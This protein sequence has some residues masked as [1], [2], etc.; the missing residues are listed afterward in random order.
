MSNTE[1]KPFE[2]AIVRRKVRQMIGREGFTSQ[3]YQP[4]EQELIARLLHGLQSFDPTRARHT[5]FV[6]AIVQRSAAH[7]LRYHRAQKR[8]H[9]RLIELQRLGSRRL[10]RWPSEATELV[11]DVEEVIAGPPQQLRWLAVQL[12][13]KSL[14]QIARDSGIPRSTL[15]HR[16][17]ELRERF[18]AANVRI[19][20]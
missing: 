7:I 2:H 12:K 4:L 16:V 20:A 1:L 11:L 18:E 8:D 15:G 10:Q 13:H 9:R 5:A 6:A 17:R 14:S 3:D 19:P